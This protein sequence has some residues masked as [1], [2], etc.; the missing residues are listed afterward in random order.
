MGAQ[1]TFGEW[2][3][4]AAY[5][6]SV[7]QAD[8]VFKSGYVLSSR[9]VPAMATGLINPFGA[10]GQAGL[11]LLAST[12]ITGQVRTAKGTMDQVDFQLSRDLAQLPGGFLAF[13]IGGEWR[14]EKLTDVP[15][16]ILDTGDIMGNPFEISPQDASRHVGALFA[17]LNI[18][19]VK[20]LE[21][22][23]SLRY[24]RYSDFG[25]TTNPK[26]ALRWQPVRTLLVRG[27]W[28]TGFRAPSLPDLFT[29]AFGTTASGVVDP[30][31]CP[32]TGNP[33]D[34][35]LRRIRTHFRRKSRPQA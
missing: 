7:N 4:A 30:A 10:S 12:Q 28:G 24:D 5:N 17:E 13:A 22:G 15:A 3:Y 31:R 33:E 20:G 29:Q 6:H 19:V 2:T 9:F 23:A 21:I 25:G 11:D 14:Q 32:V 1:G 27:A 8:D 34:C 35:W 16:P 26:V 18:P